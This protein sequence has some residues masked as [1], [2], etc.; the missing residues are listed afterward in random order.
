MSGSDSDGDL[1]RQPRHPLPPQPETPARGV[2]VTALFIYPVKGCGGI[3]LNSATLGLHGFEY[4]RHW[5]VVR[6]STHGFVT[7]RQ[8]PRM[9]LIGAPA[10]VRVRSR[11]RAG[12]MTRTWRSV[13]SNCPLSRPPPVTSIDAAAGLLRLTAPGQPELAVP[14]VLAPPPAPP[15]QVTVWRDSLD[16][17]DVGAEAAAWFSQYLGGTLLWWW[18]CAAR[19]RSSPCSFASCSQAMLPLFALPLHHSARFPF[20]PS[21]C[22]NRTHTRMCAARRHVHRARPAR[23]QGDIGPTPIEQV[24][25][26]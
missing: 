10:P 3:A 20:L 15:V 1:P 16:A 26:R 8:F 12:L 23:G 17:H 2:R 14:L 13:R 21:R 4:D 7:Q 9:C 24:P 18:V 6:A 11:S 19:P 5:L 22:T 25:A